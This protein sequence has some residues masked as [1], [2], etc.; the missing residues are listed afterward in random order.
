M[1]SVP[2]LIA[3]LVARQQHRVIMRTV[4][5]CVVGVACVAVL[6]W[7]LQQAQVAS[8]TVFLIAGGLLSALAIWQGWGVRRGWFSARATVAR[9]DRD[10]G[11]QARLITAAEFANVPQPPALYPILVHE[12]TQSIQAASQRAPSVV[13]R[14]TLLLAGL[15]LLVWLW[16]RTGTPP[17][18]LAQQ[19]PAMQPLPPPTSPPH[20][21][22]PQPQDAQGQQNNQGSQGTQTDQSRQGSQQGKQDQQGAKEQQDA[23]GKQDT[24]GTQ[25]KQGT[26]GDQGAQRGEGKQQGAQG[27]QSAQQGTPEQQPGQ[28]QGQGAGTEQTAQAQA[29]GG[30]SGSEQMGAGTEA[31]KA[32]IQQALKELSGELHTLQE[33]LEAQHVQAAPPGTSTDPD[34]YGEASLE[35]PPG[36]TNRLPLSLHVD[37]QDTQSPRKSGGVGSPT[38]QI[39][40]ATPQQAVEDVQLA[41]EAA[42]E[43]ATHQHPVPPEYQPVFERLKGSPDDR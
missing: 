13:S 39:S 15:L 10:L 17:M 22:T 31:L 40:A 14:D 7:R 23:Q 35:P 38:G 1:T 12:T 26:Q 28:Q 42:L 20:E 30:K 33:Q 25:G 3:Q 41:A 36:A 8:H 18:Q 32:E 9:L 37:A 6:M 2:G 5:T 43:S 24:Q 34:L 11:L 4:L 29:S 21:P 19:P 16:P 27:T